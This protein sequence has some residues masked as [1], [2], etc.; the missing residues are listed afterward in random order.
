MRFTKEQIMDWAAD[1]WG[2]EP[3]CEGLPKQALM[4]GWIN[5]MD[6][7]DELHG[8]ISDEDFMDY[9]YSEYR[10]MGYMDICPDCGGAIQT[11]IN[12]MSKCRISP[13]QS[14]SL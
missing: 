2:I 4:S 13:K 5:A 8:N 14:V 6:C 10:N 3:D 11:C 7:Q 1:N 9:C 12:T